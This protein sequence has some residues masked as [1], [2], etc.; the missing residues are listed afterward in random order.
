ML[1]HLKSLINYRIDLIR[2]LHNYLIN[3]RL[4]SKKYVKIHF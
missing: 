3:N 4:K 1:L 2:F